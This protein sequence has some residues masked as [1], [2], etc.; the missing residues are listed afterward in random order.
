[1]KIGAG[2]LKIWGVLDLEKTCGRI[3][4]R[5]RVILKFF[6]ESFLEKILVRL[7]WGEKCG[8]WRLVWGEKYLKEMMLTL[9]CFLSIHNYNSL[10]S[11]S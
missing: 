8:R 3:F 5:T 10:R 7:I 2:D 4:E 6:G 9:D 1:V 11:T